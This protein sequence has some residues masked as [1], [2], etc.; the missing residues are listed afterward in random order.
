MADPA[1]R[2]VTFLEYDALDELADRKHEYVH[3]IA[4]RM[5]DVTIAKAR[6]GA[7]V[8]C[9]LA[10]LDRPPYA[11][12]S[13]LLRIRVTESGNAY[14][15]DAT[16]LCGKPSTDPESDRTVLDPV[17]IVE[18]LSASTEAFVRGRK[19]MDYQKIPS[20]RHY[21]L[22]SQTEVR[23][24]HFARAESGWTYRACGPGDVIP[25]DAAR[26]AIDDVYRDVD[27][28]EPSEYAREPALEPAPA[29]A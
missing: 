4:W 16:V 13:S 24:E 27:L 1:R 10:G 7:T 11:V 2:R 28:T 19:W 14:Y 9:A 5:E 12:Y 26:I 6:L 22:V 3:G 21:L 17:V 29:E 25:L 15:P 20:L 23:I 8:L 18:I